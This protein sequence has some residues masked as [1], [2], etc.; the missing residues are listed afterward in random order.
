MGVWRSRISGNA[1]TP[2]P[3]PRRS[4]PIC[5][6]ASA[7]SDAPLFIDTHAH[8]AMSQFDDDREAVIARAHTAGVA[9]VIE[10]GY[11]LPSSRAAVDL[12]ERHPAIY[13]VVGLQPNH[14]H[15]TAPDYLEQ[16]RA[17]AAHPK[18][19]AIGEI[20]LDY[21]WMRVPPATQEEVFRAQLALARDLG[22]PV[23]IHSRDAQADTLRILA[24][25]ARGQS[26]VMHAFSGDW[27]Y[28]QAC[29]DIGF[30]LSFTGTLTYARATALHEVARRAPLAMLLT[31]TDSPYLSP[32]PYRGQR[33]EPA[34][35]RLVAER[36]AA[37]RDEPLAQV[38][39]RVWANAEGLFA[40]GEPCR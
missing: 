13:A 24:D 21:H 22:L 36:L 35:V 9:R 2:F 40:F 8:L 32:N 10:I 15:E 5:Y 29:L 6:N 3:W 17:L 25:A 20:G 39:A 18:V 11:D 19:V 12:A 31:E 4:A 14:I 16:V 38:A 28:A 37:L 1:R 23:V 34:Y 33:N 30:M 7:M 26:G 27:D